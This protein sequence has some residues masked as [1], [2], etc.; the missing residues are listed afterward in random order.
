MPIRQYLSDEAA[1]DPEAIKVMSD[2]LEQACTALHIDGN[3][4]DR[5]T[6][7]TRIIDLARKGII[8]AKALGDR[9]IAE[10]KA[11]RGL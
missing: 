1:F 5:Q 8:D 2:A 9:V 3:I 6:I 11:L 10:T 4:P 7:A